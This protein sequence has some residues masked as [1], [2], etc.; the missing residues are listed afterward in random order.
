MLEYQRL[1]SEWL[2]QKEALQAECEGLNS[3]LRNVQ[4]RAT[5]GHDSEKKKHLIVLAEMNRGH[6]NAVLELQAEIGDVLDSE[7]RTVDHELDD[8]I[9]SLR[10]QIASSENDSPQPEDIELVDADADER[11]RDLEHQLDLAQQR[12]HDALLQKEEESQKHAGMIKQLVLKQR[13]QEEDHEQ[14]V[15]SLIQIMNEMDDDRGHKV[16][17]IQQEIAGERRRVLGSVQ[18][19]S[20]KI[21]SMQET[22]SKRQREYS[23]TIGEL[24][25]KADLL[26][27]SLEARTARQ[28]R[29][30]KEALVHAKKYADEKKKFAAMHREF[31]ILNADRVRESVEHQS[32]LRELSKLDGYVLS[33]ISSG[34]SAQG[35]SGALLTGRGKRV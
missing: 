31:E 10:E 23:R 12:H 21:R 35:G 6:R 29:Q 15:T 26:K 8:E 18:N 5:A 1:Q 32:L 13:A 3:E 19:A 4:L 33:Q 14:K 9:G 27:A 7:D 17:E 34:G 24:Q 22:V 20:A 28:Q 11:L 25:G 16:E 30:T 2:S